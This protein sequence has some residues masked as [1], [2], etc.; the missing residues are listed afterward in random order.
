MSNINKETETSSYHLDDNKNRRLIGIDVIKIIACFLVVALH[1]CYPEN[2]EINSSFILYYTGVI[3]IPLFFITNGYLLFGKTASNKYY[4]YKKRDNILILV[5]LWNVLIAFGYL[6]IRNKFSNPFVSS[7]DNLF[8]QNGSFFHFWFFGALI[9]I[10]VLFPFLDKLYTEKPRYFCVLSG[11]LIFSQIIMDSLNIYTSIKHTFVFQQFIPQ[12]FRLESHLSYFLIGGIIKRYNHEL[13]QYAQW[14]YVVILYFLVIMYQYL[15]VKNIYPNVHCE[16]FYDNILVICL[17]SSIFVFLLNGKYKYGSKIIFI[18]NLTM[19]I[20]I[21]HIQILQV[22]NRYVNFDMKIM[23]L[24]CVFFVSLIIS[25]IIT[26]I[27]YT[28]RLY[29]I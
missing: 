4:T 10:Y 5:F 28:K 24:L 22:C 2:K 1:T 7:I 14:F 3:A 8:F 25:F 29:T 9:I 18:S 23:N 27:P 12:T 26:K 21:I 16:Y 11:I 13:K 6:L 19:L 15:M 17:S 20:F